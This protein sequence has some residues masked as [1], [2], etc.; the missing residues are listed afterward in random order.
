[1]EN[2]QIELSFLSLFTLLTF[3]IFLLISKYSYKFKNGILLDQ[4]FSK[5]QAFH[6]TAI[7][8][9]GG[10]AGVISL[11]IFFVIYYLIYSK[12]YFEYFIVCNLMFLIGFL[13]DIRTKIS[14]S[15]RLILM[16]VFLFV[17]IYFLPIKISNIDIPFLLV[18]MNNHFFSAVFILLCF[19]FIVN[20]ANLIDGFN[21]LLAI[22]LIIINGSQNYYKN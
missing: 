10:F 17:S 1:M 3:F 9:S 16:I 13:D 20:G 15:K 7:S 2:D 12:I 8:R 11:N 18:L 6:Q 21:G 22:N 14:P 19:L 5:P 4:D